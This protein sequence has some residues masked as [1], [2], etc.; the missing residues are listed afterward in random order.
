MRCLDAATGKL[1]WEAPFT[2]SP[3]W[4]RQFPPVVHGNL[5]IYAS[6]SGEYAYQGTREAVHVQGGDPVDFGGKEV[7]TWIY[8]NDNPYYPKDNR[9][10]LWAW[11]LDTGKVVWQKD[12]SEYGRGG[13]DC[14]ICLLDGKLFYS[15]FFGYSASQRG[16]RGLPAENNGLT[17]CLDPKTG[18][19]IWQTNKYYVTAKCTL[20]ARDGRI[21]IGGNNRAQRRDRRTASCGAWTPRTA[22]SSGSPTRSPR[23]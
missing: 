1:L 22:R 6:G 7:M 20:S 14:G 9:P 10:L 11:D 8:S 18:D 15:T 19:V 4:S 3:S 2:G 5:A 13:N 23:P 12:F 16:R 21:Y 17:A